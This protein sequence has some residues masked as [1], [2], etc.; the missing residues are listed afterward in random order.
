MQEY[1][2]KSTRTTLPRSSSG[3]SGRLLSHATAP[4]RE[5]NSPSLSLGCGAAALC[6]PVWSC[7]AFVDGLLS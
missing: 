2:Q 4:D 1:V 7:P 5:G 6:A 3:V